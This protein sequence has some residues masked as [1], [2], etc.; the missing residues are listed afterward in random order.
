LMAI[1]VGLISGAVSYFV[2]IRPL[3]LSFPEG[4]LFGG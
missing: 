4:V 3:R 2:F 1:V